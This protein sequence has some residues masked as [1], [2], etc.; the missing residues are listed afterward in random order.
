MAE[1]DVRFAT[2]KEIYKTLP[3]SFQRQWIDTPDRYWNLDEE[4][5]RAELFNQVQNNGL[6][7]LF[8]K[9]RIAFW[10]E[11]DRAAASEVLFSLDSL[12]KHF[13]TRIDLFDFFN[14]FSA[15]FPYMM[16]PVSS[17]Q[18]TL[19]ELDMLSK[20]RMIEILSVPSV[21]L[22]TGRADSRLAKVQVQIYELIQDRIY[23][24]VIQKIESSQKSVNVN[25]N[26]QATKEDA[27]KAI[28]SL[29]SVEEIEKRLK[30]VQQKRAALKSVSTIDVV[31]TQKLIRPDKIEE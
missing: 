20:E 6:F 30:V 22:R 2:G 23:G 21:D 1:L 16:I 24:P 28:E 13:K 19:K 17:Q 8:R 7:S 3:S 9:I 26:T 4:T 29:T 15:F 25:V 11:Y 10:E 27:T 12:T 14:R 5:L 18:F 31:N